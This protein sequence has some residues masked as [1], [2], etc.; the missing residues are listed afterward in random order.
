MS[1][2][3]CR[4]RN[5]HITRPFFFFCSSLMELWIRNWKPA[6]TQKILNA[7]RMWSTRPRSTSRSICR[8][9]APCTGP[10]RTQTCTDLWVTD[11]PAAS[12]LEKH[13]SAFPPTPSCMIWAAWTVKSFLIYV[14]KLHCCRRC[15]LGLVGCTGVLLNHLRLLRCSVGDGWHWGVLQRLM[16]SLTVSF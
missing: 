12:A 16:F 3:C 15:C 13:T 9:L 7:T 2:P 5:M 4:S 11:V 14:Y 1:F 6:R 10:R 8:D